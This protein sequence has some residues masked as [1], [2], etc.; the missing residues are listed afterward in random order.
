M[1]GKDVPH[2]EREVRQEDERS[3]SRQSPGDLPPRARWARDGSRTDP[4][5]HDGANR[6]APTL[7]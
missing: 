1:H 6:A 4:A 2:G 7:R 5:D 3:V